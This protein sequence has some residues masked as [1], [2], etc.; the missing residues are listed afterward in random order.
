MTLFVKTDPLPC[1]R[2]GSLGAAV[3]S[4]WLRAWVFCR[5]CD[6]EGPASYDKAPS[7]AREGAIIAWNR[8]DR[9]A[10]TQSAGNVGDPPDHRS[11]QVNRRVP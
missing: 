10:P 5:E 1:P 11:G 2:C 9:S 6:F 8:L 4:D 3:D 7:E